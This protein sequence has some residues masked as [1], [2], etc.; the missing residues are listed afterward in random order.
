MSGGGA[1]REE[2]GIPSRL[3]AEQST[4]PR[5]LHFKVLLRDAWVAQLVKDQTRGFTS[6]HDVMVHERLRYVR[7]CTDSTKPAWDS[8]SP[9]L[10]ALPPLTHAYFYMLSLS[11]SK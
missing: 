7:L 11:L 10:S 1:E 2:E 3:S 6:R 8:L 4:E 9:S 5:F